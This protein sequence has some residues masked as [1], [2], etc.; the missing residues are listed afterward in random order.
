M[1]LWRVCSLLLFQSELVFVEVL[2]HLFNIYTKVTAGP[3]CCASFKEDDA[4]I[5]GCCQLIYG[6]EQT[7]SDIEFVTLKNI[8][9]LIQVSFPPELQM[10]CTRQ[11]SRL[12]LIEGHH[13]TN[14]KSRGR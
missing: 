12:V 8:H 9:D 7:I 2:E 5:N 11:F 6:N 10:K 14:R 3:A 1:P 13:L 4:V